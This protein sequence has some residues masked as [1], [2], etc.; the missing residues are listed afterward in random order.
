MLKCRPPLAA[1]RSTLMSHLFNLTALVPPSADALGEINIFS[2]IRDLVVNST[3]EGSWISWAQVF[4]AIF[5]A[6]LLDFVQRRVVARLKKRL[7]R[8]DTPWDEALLDAV[9]APVSMLIWV[10]GIAQA[11]TFVNIDTRF[12][13]D[14]V[15]LTLIASVTW[16]ITRLIRNAQANL[17]AISDLKADQDDR[18]D[19]GTVD[20]IGKL[21]RTAVLITAVLISLQQVGINISAILAFGGI[22]GIAVGFA[23]KDLL[24]NFFGGLMIYMDRPFR[25]GDWIR[26]P[27]RNIEG[28]VES[29]GWRL[30]RIRTFDK[31]PLYVPNSIFASIAVENPQ[32][33]LNRRIY[34]TIGIRYADLPQMHAITTDVKAMLTEHPEIDAT[35]TL[36]VN[37][38]AFGPSS[39]DF[40]VYTFTRTTNWQYFHQVKH[41]ILLQISEIITG[42]GAEI[43]FPTTTLH[44]ASLPPGQGSQ[45]AGA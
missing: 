3:G 27:D 42:H 43:A 9:T 24:A 7:E 23:A 11:A 39:V 10:C 37:F 34:E 25:T 30:T 5:I 36:M 22:G 35:Q 14:I 17:V 32:R 38:N 12:M 29:I 21:A 26:S 41:Q 18:L 6:L 28:T 44:V 8:T 33:M 4:S 2:T 19:P 40:F 16:F 1:S 31:R 13:D 15:V 20:A 45:T